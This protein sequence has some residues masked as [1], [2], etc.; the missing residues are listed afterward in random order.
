MSTLAQMRNR[1]KASPGVPVS[2]DLDNVL[3]AA[4]FQIVQTF[5]LLQTSWTKP[6]VAGQGDYSIT[7]APWSITD[8][9]GITE[10][11][12]QAANDPSRWPVAQATRAQLLDYR[13]TQGSTS[14][15]GRAQ[16][17]AIKGLQTLMLY[18]TAG[19]SS[20]TIVIHGKQRPPAM[21][22]DTDVPSAMLDEWHDAIV[23]LALARSFRVED[24]AKAA[25][26][27]Q[28]AMQ[29]IAAEVGPSARE[30]GGS[31]PLKVRVGATRIRRRDPS[32]YWPGDFR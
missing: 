13:R 29:R 12:Y 21:S 16:L 24:P 23:E 28:A 30:F 5:G 17:Y 9:A 8:L 19:S 1:L 27:E 26:L 22:V 31:Q 10:I 4:Y 3:N 32:E 15:Q 14:A 18:P 20:D 6:L 7:G 11:E 25:Q 2:T